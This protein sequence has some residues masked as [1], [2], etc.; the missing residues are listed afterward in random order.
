[1]PK[2][3]EALSR[4]RIINRCLRDFG[5]V[6]LRK[7]AEKCYEAFDHEIA[8]RTLEKD[9][10]DMRFDRNL[11]YYAPIEYDRSRSAYYY[12]EPGYSID[13]FP[14]SDHDI[15]ALTFASAM[16]DQ[17]RNMAIISDFSGAVQKILDAMKISRSLSKEPGRRVVGFENCPVIRGSEWLTAI[18][19][20]I[21]RRK[22][23]GISHQRFDSAEEHYHMVHPCYLKEYRNRWYLVGYQPVNGRIQSFG[24]ERIRELKV[25]NNE[26][27]IDTG[28][29]PGLYYQNAMGV[30][31]NEEK[32]EYIILRFTAKQGKYVLTQPVHHSQEII[33][34]SDEFVVIR[35]FLTPTYEFISMILGW[36]PDVEVIE[37]AG[38]RENVQRMLR[39]MMNKYMVKTP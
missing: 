8:I 2:N 35:L 18:L 39:E 24:L 23:L 15:E 21:L 5:Y 30:I 37:P 26:P 17:Y 9:I 4:Y 32:P 16:L 38:L 1:M 33:P 6:T 14:L 29:D 22:V 10:H 36:G 11:G 20:A 31:V 7:L 13:N 28:F 25:L 3:K 19:D 27:F 12:V 34:V